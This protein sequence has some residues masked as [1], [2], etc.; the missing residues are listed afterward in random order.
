LLHTETW[1]APRGHDDGAAPLV[2]LNGF[3]Q[4]ARSWGRFGETVGHGRR[5]VAVDLPGHGDSGAVTASDLWDAAEQVAA[6]LD[7][8]PGAGDAPYDLCGYSLGGRVALHVALGHR[9][10]VG[11]LALLGATAGIDDAEAR[12]RR[13]AADDQL[14]DRLERD[15]V[16]AFLERWLAQPMFSGLGEDDAQVAARRHNT[17]AG[18]ASSLRTMG[19]GTQE[20]LWDRLDE[21][22]LPVLVVTGAADVR[23]T[24][25]GQRLRAGLPHGV[26]T[27]VPGAGHAVHLERPA[28]AADVVGHW[29]DTVGR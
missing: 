1:G 28:A 26:L 14:A 22:D 21:L 27:A 19:T 11:R 10:R 8:V 29:L 13:R 3:T 7:A 6:A 4:T 23:F 17:A 5:V 15:G 25:I 9:G 24:R 18:L 20:P 12:A 16:E 2:L